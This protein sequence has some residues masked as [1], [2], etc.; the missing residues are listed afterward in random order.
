MPQAGSATGRSAA[1]PARRSGH[2]RPRL[3]ALDLAVHLWRAKWLM[4]AIF[5]P[6]AA[7]A[8]AAA[9]SLPDSY[10]ASSR[11]LV[12]FGDE[13]VYRSG[14]ASRD[15][16]GLISP[17]ID[18]LVQSEAELLR[19]PAVAEAALAELQLARVYPSI[20]RRCEAAT[21]AQQGAAAVLHALEVGS[22][23]GNLVINA[24]FAH[25]DAGLSAEML[26]ALVKAYIAYRAEVFTDTRADRFREQRERFEQDLAEIDQAIRAYLFTNNL[27]DLAAERDTLRQ[28]YQSASGDLLVT[29]SRLRQAEAQLANYRRQIET[30]P[31]E[32]SLYVEDT[33]QQTLLAM[34]LDR[35]EN[36]SLHG[37]HSAVVQE[38]D[39]QLAQAELFLGPG[40]EAGLVRRGPNPLHQQVEAA[41]ATLQS[42]VQALRGQEAE[43]KSQIAAFEVRQRRLVE[44]APELQELERRREVA[45]RSITAMA[46]R[47]V[48]LRTRNALTLRGANTVRILEPAAAPLTGTSLRF[49]A[50]FLGVLLAALAAL[51]AGLMRAVSQRGLATPASLERTLGLPV[52][53]AIPVY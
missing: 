18:A 28:L 17:E 6:L 27:I 42:E 40:G 5:T 23:P 39:K 24:R 33:R 19:S 31:K 51:A 47:E 10:S 52:L 20:A 7:V 38:L 25:A 4:L 22:T 50:A 9:V 30:I 8:L 15:G 1:R 37:E 43:L 29:Q 16:L 32:Q 35:N 36:A 21:C 48:D 53:A 26:N 3:N 34:K 46:E 45:E 12:S 49:P 2:L 41:I 11:M 44:L 14:A 13:Y